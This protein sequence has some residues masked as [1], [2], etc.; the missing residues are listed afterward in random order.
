MTYKNCNIKT[1]E[2]I[3]IYQK[4]LI[5]IVTLDN[6]VNRHLENIHTYDHRLRI[7][8]N[9]EMVLQH[10]LFIIDRASAEQ[11]VCLENGIQ[12][13]LVCGPSLDAYFTITLVS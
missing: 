7:S 6:L 13:L 12:T 10:L 11:L 2:R 3:M 4:I 5:F 9:L 8:Q 1:L